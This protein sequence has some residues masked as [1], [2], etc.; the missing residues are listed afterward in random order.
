MIEIIID[1][2]SCKI[3]EDEEEE[4]GED[5]TLA[6]QTVFTRVQQALSYVSGKLKITAARFAAPFQTKT[7]SGAATT[8]DVSLG[9]NVRLLLQASTTLTFSNVRD[10]ERIY[11]RIKS[12]GVYT[13]SWPANVKWASGVAPTLSGTG[14]VDIVSLMYEATDDVYE[15]EFSLDKR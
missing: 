14:K 4:W 5:L 11:L 12:A 9:F 2:T 10:G 8:V 6:L 7:A 1:G 13:I 3:P 15:G